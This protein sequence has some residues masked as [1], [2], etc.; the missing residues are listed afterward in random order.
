MF[1]DTF[2]DVFALRLYKDIMRC[3][4]DLTA[5]GDWESISKNWTG[6]EDIVDDEEQELEEVSEILSSAESN[7]DY[8]D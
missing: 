5:L 8:S 2:G 1:P 3:V 4:Q 7:F 6:L